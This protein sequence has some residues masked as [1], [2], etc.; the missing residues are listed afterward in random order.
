MRVC[1]YVHVYT[2]YVVYIWSCMCRGDIAGY[3]DCNIV[4][5]LQITSYYQLTNHKTIYIQYSIHSQALQP[6]TL[7]LLLMTFELPS[8]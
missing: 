2:L 7:I 6:C 5:V 3:T 4:S 8:K 1:T